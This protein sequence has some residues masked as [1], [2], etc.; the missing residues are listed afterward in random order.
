MG[1]A[2]SYE[3]LLH[4]RP[5]GRGIWIDLDGKDPYLDE[6]LSEQFGLSPSSGGAVW[7]SITTRAAREDDS[8]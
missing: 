2:W 7:A 4:V 5:M 6:V 1:S 3:G 8:E